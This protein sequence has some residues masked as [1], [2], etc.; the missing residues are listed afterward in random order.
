MRIIRTSGTT[1]TVVVVA[2]P[3]PRPAAAPP[4]PPQQP[5][6]APRRVAHIILLGVRTQQKHLTPVV[7]WP[8]CAPAA[9]SRQYAQHALVYPLLPLPLL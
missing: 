6:C 4:P 3:P 7:A 1:T 5:S 9:S 8:P 2:P